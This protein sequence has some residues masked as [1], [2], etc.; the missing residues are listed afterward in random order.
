[1]KKIMIFLIIIVTVIF[2]F[3]LLDGSFLPQKYSGKW[4]AEGID[5]SEY[6]ISKIINYAIGAPS[7][8]NMQPWLVKIVDGSNIE[9]YVDMSKQLPVV[10]K[11]N[12]QLLMSQGTFIEKFSQGAEEFGYKVNVEYSDVQELGS[13]PLMAAISIEKISS[14]DIDTISSGTITSDDR[15]AECN[16]DKLL[17]DIM[18]EY[19]GFSY[20]YINAEADIK[21]IQGLLL[22]GT[23][24]EA[25]DSEATQELLDVFRWTEWQKNQWRYGL[26]LNTIPGILKPFVQ[27][28]MKISSKNI[29]AFGESSIKMFEDR[30]EKEI[31]YI[32]IKKDE[33]ENIDYIFAGEIYQKLSSDAVGYALRP[34][35][36]VLEEFEAMDDINAEF[37]QKY[38]ADGE[39]LI[40][41]GIQPNDGTSTA[42]NPRH[43]LQDIIID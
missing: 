25:R 38:E 10:D 37:A 35:M 12:N 33:P 14:I 27:P 24:A 6:D 18:S 5:E 42:S 20:Q 19:D 36:Q 22:Q 16:F 15:K 8:H 40:I 4:S 34:A 31:G 39:V 21:K 26:S 23:I 1:M 11:E 2:L 32:L 3:I 7:S 13:R 28:I 9:L 17:I 43:T 29:E 41:I 30:L